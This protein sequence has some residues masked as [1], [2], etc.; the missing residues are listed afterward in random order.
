[1]CCEH[2]EP[3]KYLIDNEV[4]FMPAE[5]RL[6]NKS[7]QAEV[8]IKKQASLCLL[9]LIKNH[10]ILITQNELLIYAWDN[11]HRNISFNVFYQFILSLRKGFAFLGLK[12]Q[13]ITTIP[14][15]GLVIYNNIP[16]TRL[17]KMM[18]LCICYLKVQVLIV[19]LSQVIYLNKSRFLSP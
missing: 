10:N 16:I 3:V 11:Q 19:R 18:S 15:K 8:L 1:M 2:S 7:T 6:L 5:Q 13:I 9:Y 4:I 12:T 14:R 17:E